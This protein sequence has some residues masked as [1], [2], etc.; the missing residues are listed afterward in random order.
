MTYLIFYIN[1]KPTINLIFFLIIEN[2][3]EKESYKI[4]L[5]I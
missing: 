4:L 2:S 5:K 3:V 1:N